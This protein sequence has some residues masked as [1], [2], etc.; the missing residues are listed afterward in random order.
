MKTKQLLIASAVGLSVGISPFFSFYAPNNAFAANGYVQAGNTI[1]GFVFGVQRQ[2]VGDVN[3]ELLDEYSRTLIR[4]KTNASGRYIFR[5]MKSGRFRVRVLPFGTDYEEQ[6]QD[7]E[8]QNFTSQT[9][10]GNLI[11]TGHENVQ[12]D[13][14]LR[15][16]KGNQ[17]TG[18]SESIFVQEVPAQAKQNYQK[19][20]ELLDGKKAEQGWMEI[21]SAIEIFPNY[22]DALERL[23]TEY[24]KAQHFLPA[25][26]LLT[27][28]VEINPRGYKS[29]Y[30][31]AYAR[32]SQNK[33]KEAV[34]PVQKAIS[35]NQLSVEP[36]LLEGLLQRRLKNYQQAEKQLKKAKEISKG[37]VPEVH[38]QLALLYGNNLN[39]YQEAAAELEQFL[40]VAPDSK[41]A[42]NIKKLIKQ[43]KDKALE[44][45]QK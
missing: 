16:R 13:F 7:I 37:A 1:T 38:W 44:K 41:E 10:S 36:F 4:S 19:G 45:A 31:L 30:G 15:Q 6:E 22:Y 42:E 29:W 12:R 28:A 27:R 5:G 18:R 39:R 9:S 2:P 11:T 8:I 14:Y 21:K 26:I 43:F 3:I 32:Y 20:I 17:I 33:I 25:E 23:G 34:E 40:K 24:I 35:L